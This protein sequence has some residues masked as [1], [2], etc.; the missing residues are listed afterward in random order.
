ME[1]VLY[2]EFTREDTKVVKAVAVILMVW[3]HLFAFPERLGE[4]IGYVSALGASGND[5]VDFLA[6]FGKICVLL[7]VFLGGYGTY[8]SCMK[9]NYKEI[10]EISLKKIKHLYI[11]YWKVFFVFIPVSILVGVPEI[12]VNAKDFVWNFTGLKTYY[13]GEWWF[14]TPYVLLMAAYPILHRFTEKFLSAQTEIFALLAVNTV[15]NFILPQLP[16]Y[17]WAALLPNSLVY[18]W[19]LLVAEMLPSFWMGCIAAKYG[20]LSWAKKTFSGNLLYCVLAFLIAWACAY[21]REHSR[22]PVYDFIFAPVLTAAIVVLLNNRM[23]AYVRKILSVIGRESTFIWLTHS[24]FCYYLCQKIVYAPKYPVLIAVWLL[25]ICLVSA[26]LLQTF[27]IFAGRMWGRIYRLTK[28]ST[29]D[30]T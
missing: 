2:T 15:V 13:N 12:V 14:F 5:F 1:K 26:K 4:G 30:D 22:Q 18:G 3:H 8:F 17:T 10:G 11:Q 21:I 29:T 27:Y 20:F 28:I 16:K 7:F 6:G 9:K 19:L 25:T 23:G 24:F